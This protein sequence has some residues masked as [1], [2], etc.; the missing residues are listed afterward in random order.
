MTCI[1]ARPGTMR[2]DS[3]DTGVIKRSV[4]KMFQ[5]HGYLVG[6]AGASAPLSV[7][8]FE[9]DWPRTPSV[10]TLTRWV[11]QHHDPEY[12]D[13]DECELILATRKRVFV[14]ECRAVYEA[15][16]GAIG[17]GGAYALGYLAARPQDLDGAVHAA[18]QFDPYCAGPLRKLDLK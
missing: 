5:R 7:L 6:G 1:V 13:L 11:Y 16:Y 8:E 12:L 3:R 9:V 14:V 18:C 2:S 4:A 15:A 10:E 17:S